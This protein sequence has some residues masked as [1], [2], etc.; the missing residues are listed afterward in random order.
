VIRRNDGEVEDG[1]A[2]LPAVEEEV[3]DVDRHLPVRDD[4]DDERHGEIE[5]DDSGG[6]AGRLHLSEPAAKREKERRDERGV[7]EKEVSV[8]KGMAEDEGL[9]AVREDE[10]DG[11][12]GESEEEEEREEITPARPAAGPEV[13]PEPRVL[14]CAGRFYRLLSLLVVGKVL[15]VVVIGGGPAGASAALRLAQFGFEVALFDRG[16]PRRQHLAETLPSSIRVVLETLGLDLPDDVVVTRPPEHLVY[17]GEMRG[18]RPWTGVPENESS[19]LVW[20]GPFDRYL[21]ERAR[22]AARLLET[23]VRRADREKGVWRVETIDGESVRSRILVDASGRTGIL[24]RSLRTK[25]QRFRT[26]ALTGHFRTAEDSPP[27]LIEA[28]ESG[29]IWSAPLANGLRDVTVMVDRSSDDREALYQRAIESTK[30]ARRLVAAAEAHGEIRGIDATPYGAREYA[31]QDFFLVGDAASFV[32]PLSAHGVHKAMDGALAAAVSVRTIL[33]RPE[34][35]KDA[36]DFYQARE[37]NIVR[38]TTDRIRGLYRQET[39]FPGSDFWQKRAEGVDSVMRSAAPRSP[40][41]PGD[42][43]R[44]SA[45]VRLVEAA[46]LEGDF[47][48]RREVLVA[49]EQERPVRFLGGISLPDVYKEVVSAPS[50]EA[51]ASRSPLGFDQAFAAIEWLYHSGYLERRPTNEI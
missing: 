15:D 25:E 49:D 9:D 44:A 20:R 32:D 6:D 47:I 1:E 11:G 2:S 23:T 10:D 36:V 28:F 30:Q 38:I 26:L 19:L 37:E 22:S 7:D 24:A 45:S 40:L 31:G 34:R 12:L 13:I 4:S 48:E 18:S 46:V 43:L 42:V 33:E 17:W 8:E 5:S 35:S 3:L 41:D 39:R 14:H 27:T 21:R 29:F 50:V 51:A 16:E